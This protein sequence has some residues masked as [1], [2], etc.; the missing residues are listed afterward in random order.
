MIGWGM[1]ALMGFV[2]LAAVSIVVP[3]LGGVIR[4]LFVAAVVLLFLG[5]IFELPKDR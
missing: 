4:F 2:G 1:L 3:G 5:T